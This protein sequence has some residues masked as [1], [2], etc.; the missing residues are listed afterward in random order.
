[1]SNK[2]KRT[3]MDDIIGYISLLEKAVA[4]FIESSAVVTTEIKNP[5][6]SQEQFDEL[7]AMIHFGK[8]ELFGKFGSLEHLMTRD[9]LNEGFLLE[10]HHCENLGA[11]HEHGKRVERRAIW[12]ITYKGRLELARLKGEL[13]R[14]Q[15]E[16]REQGWF[17]RNQKYIL[18]IS[19]A[20]GLLV[21]QTIATFFI[22]KIT[23]P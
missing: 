22:H 1:M 16:K 7:K 23:N 3:A 18:P 17:Y 13:A 4:L 15:K 8:G 21:L 14:M 10:T 11:E 12:G 6:L 2:E 20:L 9:L 5:S 19:G